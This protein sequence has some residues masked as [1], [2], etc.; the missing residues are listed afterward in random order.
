MHPLLPQPSDPGI[1]KNSRGIYLNAKVAMLHSALFV[2]Y[3]KTEIK[4]I[5]RKN[6]NW[7]L[8]TRS[9]I[10]YIVNIR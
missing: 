5:L 1:I 9:I 6:R 7:F 4:K 8:T 2:N 3:I 10:S